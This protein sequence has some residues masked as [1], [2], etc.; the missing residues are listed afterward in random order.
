MIKEKVEDSPK[1]KLWKKHLLA[2]GL[3][4]HKVEEKFTRHRYNG[5][6]LFSTLLLDA[7]TPEGQ[8]IPPICFLKGEVVSMLICLI[9][10]NS[11]EKYLLLVKQRRITE[12][13]F[14]YEHPAGMVDADAAPKAIAIKEIQEE[15]GLKI[16]ENEIKELGNGQRFFPSTGT[17]DEAMYFYYCELKMPLQE[18][19]AINNQEHGAQYEQE[20]IS[21]HVFK[22]EEGHRKITNTNGLLLNYLYLNEIEDYQTLKKLR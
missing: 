1:F 14:T 7:S 15:T 18:I 19:L 16:H 22:F 20:N 8:K 4:I 17:S 21:T 13:G 2:N 9:D 11:L 12:G 10:E 3:T 6:V 5:E